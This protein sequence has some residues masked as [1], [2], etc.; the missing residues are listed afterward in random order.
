[1]V[2]QNES[3][4]EGS[5]G[6]R[7]VRSF[8][9]RAG[10]ITRAQERALA[11]LW[12]RYG[13][14][15]ADSGDLGAVFG[16]EAP[17]FLEIGFGMGDALA[18]MAR[19]RPGHDFLGID[20]HE[21]GIGRVMTLLESDE[22]CNVRIL[23]GDAVDLLRRHL[24]PVSLQ[25]IMVFFPDPWPKKRHHKRRLVQPAF[26]EWCARVLVPGGVLHLATD[27]EPYAQV[28]LEVGEAAPGYRNVHGEGAFAP[29]RGDRPATRFE[30]R[31]ER[32]GHSIFD[33]HF[34]RR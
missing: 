29:D 1:M 20:V 30:R 9:R 4:P 8:V 2:E 13:L 18:Q 14:E 33:L 27:W 5:C 25:G 34:V 17:R 11:E 19:E 3:D 22:V 24:A 21:A 23:R 26:F 6:S 10:R 32:L 16:R 12:P 31:G 28:M 15:A 7:R